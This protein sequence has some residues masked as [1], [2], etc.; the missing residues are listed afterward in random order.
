MWPHRC[1]LSFPEHRVFKAHLCCG[2]CQNSTPVC[3]G[4]LFLCRDRTL[5]SSARS[6]T[7]GHLGCSHVLGI[8]SSAAV[9]VHGHVLCGCSLSFLLGSARGDVAGSDGS[10]ALN[11]G[12]AAVLFSQ[13]AV[14]CTVFVHDPKSS[15]SF[16]G[17][18][19]LEAA[20]EK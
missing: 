2:R 19:I 12:R 7:D 3:S 13:T 11:S 17:N 5:P 15:N 1:L 16:P 4:S 18:K 20:K 9:T 14:P 8:V 6:A 10:S